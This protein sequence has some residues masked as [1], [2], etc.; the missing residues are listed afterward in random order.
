MQFYSKSSSHFIPAHLRA[1]AILCQAV[2]N[3]RCLQSKLNASSLSHTPCG[4]AACADLS[5]AKVGPLAQTDG[6]ELAGRHTQATVRP[7]DQTCAARQQGGVAPSGKPGSPSPGWSEP[8]PRDIPSFPRGKP[9]PGLLG[10]CPSDSGAAM[11]T[12]DP[13]PHT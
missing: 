11:S 2:T 10:L 7:T 12:A 13:S 4:Q 9:S 6:A 8:T 1:L 3:G 5:S